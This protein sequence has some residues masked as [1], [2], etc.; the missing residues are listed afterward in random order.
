MTARDLRDALIRDA[1]LTDA[2]VARLT[3]RNARRVRLSRL[4]ASASPPPTL[5]RRLAAWIR[6]AAPAHNTHCPQPA[7]RD[8]R[9]DGETP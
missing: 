7:P 9:A 8:S 2:D 4:A 5:W 3:A 6:A 1:D